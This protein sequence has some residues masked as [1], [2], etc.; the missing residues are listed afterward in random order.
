MN[1]VIPRWLRIAAALLL[2]AVA[3][4]AMASKQV[5][6]GTGDLGVII[7]RAVGKVLIVET[8]TQTRITEVEGLGNL[9]H[10]SLVYSRDERYAYVFGRE[11]GLSK[12]DM[13]RGTLVKRIVQSGNSIGGAISQDGRLVAVS[14][15]KPGGVKVF[16]AETLELVA[17]IPAEY[18]NHGELSKVIG[19]VDAPGQRFI[20]TLWDAGEIWIA[21]MHDPAKPKI[22]KFK[23]IGKFPYDALITPDGRYYIAG[24]FGEDGL[25]KLD[26]WNLE[27]GVERI[28]PGYGRGEKKMPVYKMPH[29]EGWAAAGDMMLVPAIGRHE[30]LIINQRN[31]KE[32]GRI[33]MHGQPVFVMARPDG[34]QGEGAGSGYD[35]KGWFTD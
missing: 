26:L 23:D 14:N 22:T 2:V 18:G 4:C 1:N 35:R 16:N 27:A 3:G 5:L 29:L 8:T 7:E 28:M 11:G 34:R 30:V 31:L 33:A 13:L 19:L 6:R 20:F 25:V 17:D 12:V 15:Y 32:A 24:L 21:D 9:A 10:A